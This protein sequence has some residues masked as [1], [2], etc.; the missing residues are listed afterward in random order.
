ME[1]GWKTPFCRLGHSTAVELGFA[2]LALWGSF[3]ENIDWKLTDTDWMTGKSHSRDHLTTQIEEGK[4]GKEMFGHGSWFKAI[5]VRY[6]ELSHG[7]VIKTNAVWVYR[8]T[9]LSVI[10]VGVSILGAYK[11]NYLINNS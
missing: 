2:F 4:I 9:S 11:V 10:G 3:W 6:S 8:S 7:L 5:S 1:V